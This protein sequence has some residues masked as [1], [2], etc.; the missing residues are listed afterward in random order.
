MKA[1]THSDGQRC[2]RFEWERALH[3]LDLPSTTHHVGLA[4]ATYANGDDGGNAHPG[5]DRLAADCRLTTR[6]IRTHLAK[7]RTLRLIVRISRGWANQFGSTADVY[8]LQIP[9]DVHTLPRVSNH[10]AL[11]GNRDRSLPSGPG[12]S[13]ARK[14]DAPPPEPGDALQETDVR[15]AGRGVP[16]TM[17]DTRDGNHPKPNMSPSVTLAWTR[18]RA[19]VSRHVYVPDEHEVSCTICSLPQHHPSHIS[20]DRTNSS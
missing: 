7:L 2:T 14:V 11:R 20:T 5:E 12:R 9:S 6:T 16:D 18:A 3:F 8:Q 13:G 17:D 1:S 4:L 10:P 15:G 19:A